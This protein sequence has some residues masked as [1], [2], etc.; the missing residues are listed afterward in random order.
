M[1]LSDFDDLSFTDQTA[2]TEAA[3]A[4][5]GPVVNAGA[6]LGADPREFTLLVVGVLVTCVRA[7][8]VDEETCREMFEGAL[9]SAARAEQETVV[10]VSALM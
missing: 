8:G 9:E 3:M 1:N 2:V 6:R 10:D 5:I 7:N 4:F